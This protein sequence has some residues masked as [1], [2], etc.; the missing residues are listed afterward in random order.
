MATTKTQG[1]NNPTIAAGRTREDIPS[2][3]NKVA[4]VIIIIKFDFLYFNYLFL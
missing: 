2:L 4:E 3:K 1:V